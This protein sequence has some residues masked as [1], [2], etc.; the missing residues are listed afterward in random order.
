MFSYGLIKKGIFRES[1]RLATLKHYQNLFDA[2]FDVQFA[3][4]EDPNVPA[5]L[6]KLWLRQMPAPLLLYKNFE[7]CLSIVSDSMFFLF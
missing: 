1:A 3:D 7:E 6:I 4:N 2:G 5:C